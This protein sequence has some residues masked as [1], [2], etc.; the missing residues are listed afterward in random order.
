MIEAK[1]VKPGEKFLLIVPDPIPEKFKAPPSSPDDASLEESLQNWTDLNGSVVTVDDVDG[2]STTECTNGIDAWVEESDLSLP[3]EW[4]YSLND[5]AKFVVRVPD[6]IPDGIFFTDGA[7]R[8]G[9][10]ALNGATVSIMRRDYFK[11]EPT[12]V[13]K[14]DGVETVGVAESVFNVP[15]EWLNPPVAVAVKGAAPRFKVGDAV[16]LV[17]EKGRYK[18]NVYIVTEPRALN[19]LNAENHCG[20]GAVFRAGDTPFYEKCAELA[21]DFRAGDHVKVLEVGGAFPENAAKIIGRVYEVADAGKKYPDGAQGDMYLKDEPRYC[22]TSDWLQH[23]GINEPLSDPSPV[24]SSEPDSPINDIEHERRACRKAREER[25][26]AIVE[27]DALRVEFEAV[28]KS[29]A[30]YGADNV[31]LKQEIDKIKESRDFLYGSQGRACSDRDMWKDKHEHSYEE[32]SKTKQELELER[33]ANLRL[34]YELSTRPLPRPPE[35]LLE[36]GVKRVKAEAGYMFGHAIW[37]VMATAVLGGRCVKGASRGARNWFKD[38][39]QRSEFLPRLDYELVPNVLGVTFYFVLA[40]MFCAM[41]LPVW[42]AINLHD[43]ERPSNRIEA[44][45]CPA[46]H[47]TQ[48]TDIRV[49]EW[50]EAKKAR[51]WM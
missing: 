35:S 1:D 14:S 7:W 27:R 25:D 20:E 36:R 19:W 45:A 43:S 5:G 32:W 24:E 49:R 22:Y 17:G 31:R 26:A 33:E 29:A 37:A 51:R 16:R 13:R 10:K 23:V 39:I 38:Q 50:I 28:K 18:D 34:R 47:P 15:L 11:G 41:V 21:T 9:M 8:A 44:I 12:Y 3:L 30:C 6:P 42:R 40:T 4:L 48:E 46:P 2:E